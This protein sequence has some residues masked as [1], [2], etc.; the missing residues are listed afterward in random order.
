VNR[1]F[2]ASIWI[3][4]ALV[5]GGSLASTARAASDVETLV[6]DNN[7]FDMW[8]ADFRGMDGGTQLFVSAAVQKTFVDVNEKGTEAAAATYVVCCINGISGPPAPPL[9]FRADHP[10]LFLIQDRRTGT[11]LFM[12]RV[13][14]PSQ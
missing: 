3:V 4:G 2:V 7:A 13:M 11:I 14:D 9:V 10:F 1:R 8:N 5:V 6:K 12:G